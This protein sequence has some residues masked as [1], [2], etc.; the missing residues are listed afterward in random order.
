M[1]Y[2]LLL[3]LVFGFV[4]FTFAVPANEE[5]NEEESDQNAIEEDPDLDKYRGTGKVIYGPR[6]LSLSLERLTPST[7]SRRH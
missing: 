6:Y 5:E 2:S 7:S 1:K 3:L 4:A